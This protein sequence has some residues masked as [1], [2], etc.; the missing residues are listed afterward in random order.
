MPP[1]SQV[2]IDQ[3]LTNV[4]IMF[5]NE[6]YVGD[7]VFP[8]APVNKRSD[9]YFV[10]NRADFTSGS[11]V[12]TNDMP[13]S[14]RRPGSEADERDY[15]V[16]TQSYYA[17]EYALRHLVTDAEAAYSD[18]PLQPEIDATIFLT[19]QLLI[20]NERR[21][22]NLAM[23]PANYTSGNTEDLTTGGSGTSW[24]QYASAN[25]NPFTDIKAGRL[26]VTKGLIRDPNAMA[27]TIGAART[28]A[29]HPLVKELVKY[30][31]ADALTREGLP[32]VLR[33]LKVIEAGA[34]SNTA[35]PGLAINSE[36]I[37]AAADGSDAALIYFQNPSPSIRSVAYAYTFEA[38]D[39]TTGTRGLAVRKWREE[40]RKGTMVEV[41]FLRDWKFIGVDSSSLATGGYLITG[42]N[43]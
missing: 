31:H 34:Q 32:K 21:V 27:L 23:N 26:A 24:A 38:P 39:D 9:K 33:G 42:V 14:Y 3:A 17:D 5:K 22:S 2:H 18:S 4:S 6:I 11:M 37:F 19:E 40:R 10:Y 15:G 12:D 1:I 41:S 29:D 30:V 8:I 35:A 13:Q 43:N 28:L 20:D 25:S 7:Q 16:S 36:Y